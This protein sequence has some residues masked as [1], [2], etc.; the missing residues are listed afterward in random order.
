MKIMVWKALFMIHDIYIYTYMYIYG[1]TKSSNS[2]DCFNTE[3]YGFGIIQ[4][5]RNHDVEPT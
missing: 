2:L 1:D 4:F 3:T 5:F